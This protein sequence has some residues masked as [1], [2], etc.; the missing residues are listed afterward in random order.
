MIILPSNLNYAIA[1]AG[2]VRLTKNSTGATVL[3]TPYAN[4]MTTGFTSSQIYAMAQ[5]ARA[6]RFDY[7][8]EGTC[9]LS[10]EVFELKWLPIILGGSEWTA[11]TYDLFVRKEFTIAATYDL[12]DTPNTGTLSIFKLEADNVGHKSEITEG[13]PASNP[14][15]YSITGSTVTFNAGDV[16]EKAVAYYMKD[17]GATAEKYVVTASEFPES[18]TIDCVTSIRSKYNGVDEELQFVAKNARPISEFTINFSETEVT[19]I[20]V[21]FDLLPDENGNLCEFI[22]P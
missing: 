9:A 8:R 14:D 10:M 3:Y 22:R 1:D 4:S 13:T 6:V 15:E 2:D 11:G 19:T 17:S 12:V 5:G 21:T 16:G 20:D 7:G 18:Y